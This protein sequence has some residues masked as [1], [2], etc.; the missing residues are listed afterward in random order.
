RLLRKRTRKPKRLQTRMQVTNSSGTLPP[1]IDPVC[2]MS[3]QPARAAGSHQHEGKT[4]FFCA[5]GCLEKFKADPS[6]YLQKREAPSPLVQLPPIAPVPP[7]APVQAAIYTCP[8]HPEIRQ[9]GPGSC[10]ICGMALE[11][12]MATAEEGP[13]PELVDMTRRFW[14]ATIFS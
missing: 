5:R 8:M 14:I 4:Y 2:G 7:T 12:E 13:N 3:V 11:P 9:K 6:R 1:E 10:P